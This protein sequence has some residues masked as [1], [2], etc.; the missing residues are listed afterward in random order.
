MGRG[1]ATEEQPIDEIRPT[2]NRTVGLRKYMGLLSERPQSQ[3]HERLAQGIAHSQQLHLRPRCGHQETIEIDMCHR[4]HDNGEE[5]PVARCDAVSDLPPRPKNEVEHLSWRIGK[6]NGDR[7][8]MAGPVI[9]R[10]VATRKTRYR[11]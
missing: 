8:D 3:L 9:D 4:L 2:H 10:G 11:W 7:G 6:S 5:T 1:L